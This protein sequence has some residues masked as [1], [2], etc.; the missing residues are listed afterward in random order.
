MIFDAHSDIWSDV[1]VKRIRG[2]KDIFRKYHYQRLLKGGIEGAIFVMW[3]DPPYDKEP[4]KRLEQI[5]DAVMQE[6]HDC[7]DI[8]HIVHDHREMMHARTKGIFYTFLGCE[9]L[10]GIGEDIDRLDELYDF[11]VRHASLTWNEQNLL[12]AGIRGD[13]DSGLTELGIQALRRIEKLH[14]ILDVS[15][16]N[17]KS[18]W[19][20][21]EHATGPVAATHSNCRSLC[22][23]PRNLSDDM[24]RAI[25]QTEGMIGVNAYAPF[26]AENQRERTVDRL[27]AHVDHIVRIAGIEH[28]GFGFDFFEFLESPGID[29]NFAGT[30]GGYEETVDGN[31]GVAA[32]SEALLGL[33]DA[34]QAQNMLAALNLIGFSKTEIEKLSYENWHDF[35]RMVL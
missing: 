25:A 3:I 35:I 20:V 8:L 4:E 14:M 33:A 19:D 24:I 15:H 17:D 2:E 13:T 12:A 1:T 29:G 6:I 9:G 30:G 10:S 11:G 16:L 21:M 18:F 23:V 32:G 28:V 27:A 31:A 22:D 34:S 26:A 5:M 7:E